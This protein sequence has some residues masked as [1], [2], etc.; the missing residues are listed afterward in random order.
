MTEPHRTSVLVAFDEVDMYGIVHHSKHLVYL[1]RARIALFSDHGLNPGNLAETD[2]GLVVVDAKLQFKN[3]ARFQDELVV[4]TLVNRIS[5]VTTTLDYRILRGQEVI[6]AG[7]LRLAAVDAN[8][9]PR[10]LP[11]EAKTALEQYEP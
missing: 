5:P 9:R 1:E 7:V 10:R 8:G 4:E 11:P 2:F 6:M 3:P